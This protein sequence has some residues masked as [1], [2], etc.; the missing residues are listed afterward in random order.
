[1]T[2]SRA[3][4]A[5]MTPYEDD[6]PF[7]EVIEVGPDVVPLGAEPRADPAEAADHLV[8]AEQDAV[9]VAD[10]ADTLEVA[11]PEAVNEPPEFCTGSMITIATVSGPACSIVESRSSSSIA[12]NCSSVSPSGRW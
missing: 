2:A 8:G 6:R 12:V 11:R 3:I 10:L 5:P 1:M 4:T 9:A 7:A